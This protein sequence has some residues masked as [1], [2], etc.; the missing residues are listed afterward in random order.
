M[1]DVDDNSKKDIENEY[2]I[3]KLNENEYNNLINYCIQDKSLMFNRK[4]FKFYIIHRLSFVIF[5]NLFLKCN[6]QEI[7][8][9]YPKLINIFKLIWNFS[10]Y[11][12]CYP[13]ILDENEINNEILYILNY[14]LFNKNNELYN[15]I[16]YFDTIL[17]FNYFSS[18]GLDGPLL[19]LATLHKYE[20]LCINIIK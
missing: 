1:N 16:L 5:N 2:K 19:H 14:R 20:K 12:A 10:G 17:K 8:S 4:R 3:N 15:N 11:V 7:K 9:L 6:C 18:D 13:T